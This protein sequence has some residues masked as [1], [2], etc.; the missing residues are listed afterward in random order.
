MA[1]KV[2]TAPAS[3]PITA[4]T[5]KNWLKVDTSADDTLIEALIASCRVWVEN[6]CR[7]GLLEQTITETWDTWPEDWR[8][9][10]S[11][12]R[13]VSGIYY[14]DTNGDQQTLSSAFYKV[15]NIGF[16]ARV[17][18]KYGQSLPTLYDEVNAVSAV[19]TVGWDSASAIPGPI[20]TAMELMIADNYENRQDSIKRLPTAAEY[21]LQGSG[22]R[23]WEFKGA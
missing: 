6:H 12:L 1:W 19:Y 8:L 5:A 17:A 23:V 15:D 11:P 18:R 16:P 4:A 13:E 22:Y 20:I 2:S 7:L 9:G 14:L 3:E 21:L 10:V